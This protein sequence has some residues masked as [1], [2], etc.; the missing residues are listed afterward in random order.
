MKKFIAISLLSFSL[1]LLAVASTVVGHSNTTLSNGLVGYW[2][3]DG[4]TTNWRT[5]QT[6]DTSGSGNDGSLVSMSTSTTPVAG[7]IGSAFNFTS[8]GFIDVPYSAS[9]APTNALTVSVWFKYSGLLSI[10]QKFVSKTETGGYTLFIAQP[11]GD[12]CTGNYLCFAVRIGGVYKFA[13]YNTSNLTAGSWYHLVG[14]YDGNSLNLYVNGVLVATAPAT[15]AIQYAVNNHLCIGYEPSST[16]CSVDN[17]VKG[18][19]DDVRIYNRALSTSEVQQLY[20]NGGGTLAH[21]NTTLS[22]GLVGYWPMDGNT[23]SWT[24]GQTKDQSGAGNNGSLVSMSTSTT[25]VTGKVGG[26]FNFN[27]TSYVN[28]PDSASLD[29]GNLITVSAWIYPTSNASYAPFAA[30][31][32]AA[33]TVGWEIANNSGTLRTTLRGSLVNVTAGALTLNKWQMGTFTYDGATLKLYLNGTLVGSATGSATLNSSVDLWIGKRLVNNNTFTG[34]IDDVR[35]YNRVLSASEIAQ[36][37]KNGGGTVAQSNATMLANGLVGYLPLD[38]TLTSWVTGITRDLS[39]N[40]GNATLNGLSTSTT[41]IAGKVGGAMKFSGA[42]SQYVQEGGFTDL[43]TSNKPYTLS[44]WIKPT[45]SSQTGDILHISANATGTGWCLSM[46]QIASGK[47]KA[48][49]WSPTPTTVT[50]ATTLSPNKWYHIVH[51]WSPSGGLRIY[52][53]GL[54]DGSTAQTAF[55]A[56]G[57][58]NYLTVGSPASGGGCSTD[59]G[60]GFAGS[61]DDVRVYNR[62]L[63]ASE[64]QLLYTSTK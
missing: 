28:V 52:V 6:T 62:E 45:T 33:G 51:T 56:S 48:L 10:D 54:L 15:G 36:L 47:A 13:Q 46:I 39:G 24:T 16:T 1:P 41:P 63:S 43:G 19:M 30:K 55:S 21:S 61:I 12:N 17:H 37:Y 8:G 35:V 20:V 40:G 44:T 38:G 11:S 50:G 34:R 9:L 57:L 32:D 31:V 59:A 26:T 25:P 4:N 60:T 23:T 49:S 53:N 27:G 14:T 18:V 42:S 22:T 2:P 5:G 58:S 29:T 3:M 7:K 64:V